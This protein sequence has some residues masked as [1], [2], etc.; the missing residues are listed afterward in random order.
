MP[1]SEPMKAAILLAILLAPLAIV[2]AM[3]TLFLALVISNGLEALTS[4]VKR[5]SIGTYAGV[6]GF[7]GGFFED[8]LDLDLVR[9]ILAI[10]SGLKNHL[11]DD[12]AALFSQITNVLERLENME[13]EWKTRKT[14]PRVSEASAPPPPPTLSTGTQGSA[15][16]AAVA[17]PAASPVSSDQRSEKSKALPD[18][19]AGSATSAAFPAFPSAG[20]WPETGSAGGFQGAAFDSGWGVASGSAG[21]WGDAAPAWPEANSQLGAFPATGFEAAETSWPAAGRPWD[22]WDPTRPAPQR[23]SNFTSSALLRTW[24]KCNEI[25][26]ASSNDSCE[27]LPKLQVCLSTESR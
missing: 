18:G 13:R 20:A 15:A 1:L 11:P 6:G 23:P 4:A 9:V 26:I 19:T 3:A 10:A 12:G 7:A 8:R 5:Q 24:K 27:P 21:G 25:K 16:A 17:F 2:L 14:R 22:L